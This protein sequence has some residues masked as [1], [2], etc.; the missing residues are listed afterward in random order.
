MGRKKNKLSVNTS[1]IR[2][3]TIQPLPTVSRR[4]P[5][6]TRNDRNTTRTK[7]TFLR[8]LLEILTLVQVAALVAAKDG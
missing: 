3:S 1:A 6:A 5:V 8:R 4:L 7:N 2:A